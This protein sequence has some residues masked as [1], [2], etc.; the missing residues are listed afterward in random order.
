[1]NQ[2][3]I[4]SKGK[5][6]F[7]E[8]SSKL[9]LDDPKC[10]VRYVQSLDE[11][12]ACTM[13]ADA[14]YVVI[15][16]KKRDCVREDAGEHSEDKSEK[17]KDASVRKYVEKRSKAQCHPQKSAADRDKY[18]EWVTRYVNAHL[19][20]N[21]NLD[22]ISAYLYIS[23]NYMSSI[24]S[25][26]MGMPLKDYIIRQRMERARQML[27]SSNL[28]IRDIAALVGY[29]SASHFSAEFRKT[30]H[31]KP[32]D[33]RRNRTGGSAFSDMKCNKTAYPSAARQLTSP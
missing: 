31:E 20:E 28:P 27:L 23:K 6:C 29:S 22:K 12:R 4:V 2:Y 11:L 25:H 8:L 18:V 13:D 30:F 26:K 15:K 10:T 3:L 16:M 17:N 33:Y 14:E 7:R 19:G 5:E 1:M 21:L 9:M 24:F 32:S